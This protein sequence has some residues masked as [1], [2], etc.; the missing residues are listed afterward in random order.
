MWKRWLVLALLAAGVVISYIDRMNF[1]VVLVMKDFQ[2][3]F[4]VT[5]ADRG[6]L[7]SAFFWS[8]TLLQ[9]PAG[10][11]VD[12]YGI[13][14][15]YAIGFFL[16]S[17]VSAGTAFL[18]STAQMIAARLM[19]GVGEAIAGPASIKWIYSHFPEER[20]GFATGLYFSGTKVGLAIGAPVT[21]WLSQQWGWRGMFLILGLGAMV[22]LIPWLL[23][24]RRGRGQSKG[25]GCAFCQSRN[26]VVLGASENAGDGRHTAR[27]FR[28]S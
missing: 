26:S 11:I 22:W 19:L 7:N 8:Y 3:E 23:L 10:W 18:G 15:P 25:A 9:I 20:R 1:S 5:D 21:I 4:P 6:L 13:R 24:M 2:R 17:G 14:T 28:L 16:W 27:Q 12:R